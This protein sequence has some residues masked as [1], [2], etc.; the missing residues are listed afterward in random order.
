MVAN[1]NKLLNELNVM[2]EQSACPLPELFRIFHDLSDRK[3]GIRA[4]Q[5]S[6]N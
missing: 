1:E 3:Y 5:R 6:N 4:T 2:D